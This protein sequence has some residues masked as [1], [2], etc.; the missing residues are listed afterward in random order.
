MLCGVV[1]ELLL[2]LLLGDRWWRVFCFHLGVF[3]LLQQRP[4]W[5]APSCLSGA[6]AGKQS[7]MALEKAIA[8]ARRVKEVSLSFG[9][10]R[11]CLRL[12]LTVRGFSDLS[13]CSCNAGL[14]L[15][16]RTHARAWT[17]MLQNDVRGRTRGLAELIRALKNA[18]YAGLRPH[19]LYKQANR[20][21]KRLLRLA[22]VMF[23]KNSAAGGGGGK[24]KKNKKKKK[25]ATAVVNE[26]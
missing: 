6:V 7:I 18:G 1:F 10:Y 2:L 23:T 12:D 11:R 14:D 3:F 24:N 4:A 8:R 26:F 9:C 5:V 15:P 21:R 16:T 17:K 19:P 20:Q 25:T 13:H 22:G